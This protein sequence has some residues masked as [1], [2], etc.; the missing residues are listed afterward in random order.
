[1]DGICGRNNNGI[2][3]GK[4]LYGNKNIK[5]Y[6]WNRLSIICEQRDHHNATLT[7]EEAISFSKRFDL[8]KMSFYKRTEANILYQVKMIK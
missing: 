2:I 1:M 5:S 6:K 3:E 8:G 7:V 4:C